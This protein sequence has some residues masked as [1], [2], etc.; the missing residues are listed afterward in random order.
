MENSIGIF[1]WKQVF[2]DGLLEFNQYT[3]E[4]L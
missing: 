4:K 1:N 2:A 3:N